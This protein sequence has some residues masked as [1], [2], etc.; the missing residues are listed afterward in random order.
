MLSGWSTNGQLA[1]PVCMTQQK[2]LRLRNGGKFLWFDYHECFLPRNH[3]FMRNGTS[4]RKDRTFTGGP[5]RRISGN[6]FM[7][8]W[9]TT[10]W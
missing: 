5:P 1:C 7:L 8:R 9:N 4:F 10:Q 3:T 2:A 6:N